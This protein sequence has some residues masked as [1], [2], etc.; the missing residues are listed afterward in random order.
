MLIIRTPPLNVRNLKFLGIPS[1]YLH[2]ISES[3]AF[4]INIYTILEPESTPFWTVFEPFPPSNR[5]KRSNFFSACGRLDFS[6]FSILLNS[7]LLFT[8]NSQM[9]AIP[10][11]CRGV[12]IINTPVVLFLSKSRIFLENELYPFLHTPNSRG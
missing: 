1:Y 7:F 12:L 11:Y 3:W 4:L 9:F 10:F 5:Q 6:D 2:K 8:Q